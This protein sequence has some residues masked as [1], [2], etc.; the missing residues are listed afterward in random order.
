MGHH[1]PMATHED[2]PP[3]PQL[4]FPQPPQLDHRNSGSKVSDGEMSGWMSLYAA[5]PRHRRDSDLM[6]SSE[7]TLDSEWHS[8]SSDLGW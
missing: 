5:S 1:L 3:P 6:E 4:D 8:V 7:T 2:Y